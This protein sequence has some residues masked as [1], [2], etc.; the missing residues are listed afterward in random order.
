MV[1]RPAAAGWIERQPITKA[2]DEKMQGAFVMG[3]SLDPARKAPPCAAVSAVLAL[4]GDPRDD[5]VFFSD[6]PISL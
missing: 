1:R 4:P 2:P 3:L 5:S 6:R